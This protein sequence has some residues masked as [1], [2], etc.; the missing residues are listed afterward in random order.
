MEKT[1]VNLSISVQ[2]QG[3]VNDKLSENLT[4]W[5]EFTFAVNVTV[6]LSENLVTWYKY[7][8]AVCRNIATLQISLYVLNRL[9][10]EKSAR[11]MLK[12]FSE[13][14]S[15]VK[16]LYQTLALI[17]E[18]TMYNPVPSA[19]W[20]WRFSETAH[21]VFVQHTTRILPSFELSNIQ[22]FFL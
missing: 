9:R 5:Y 10:S 22:Q 3:T 4:T 19:G 11:K 13:T 6:K 17:S 7:T 14:V 18:F 16:Q 15:N 21:C 20:V 1:G 12:R 2:L 8:F